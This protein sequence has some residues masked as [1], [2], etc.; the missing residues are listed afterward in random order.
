MLIFMEEVFLVRATDTLMTC[1]MHWL[2]DILPT[3]QILFEFS[4]QMLLLAIC[5]RCTTLCVS[6]SC[7]QLFAFV[8]F[9]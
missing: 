3:H 9:S 4:L 8:I 7:T 2:L 6:I 1:Q 5:T